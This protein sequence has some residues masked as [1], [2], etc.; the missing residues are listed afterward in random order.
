MTYEQELAAMKE[1]AVAEKISA[2]DY[3]QYLMTVQDLAPYGYKDLGA[4]LIGV[5]RNFHKKAEKNAKDF[6]A[7]YPD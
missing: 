1:K 5:M 6:L 4:A 3:A 7:K 2:W